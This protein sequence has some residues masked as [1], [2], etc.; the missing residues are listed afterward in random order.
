MKWGHK[1]IQAFVKGGVEEEKGAAGVAISP[2]PSL[3]SP[4]GWAD[5]AMKAAAGDYFKVLESGNNT[6]PTS[7]PLLLPSLLSPLVVATVPG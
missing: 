5:H 4:P 3:P 1:Q 6:H 2:A 7:Q